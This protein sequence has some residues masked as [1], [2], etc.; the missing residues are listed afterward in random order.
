[1]PHIQS[2]PIKTHITQFHRRSIMV[3][4]IILFFILSPGIILF[5][6]GYRFNFT[7]RTVESTGVLSIDIQPDTANVFVNDILIT[8]SMP[9]RLTNLAPNTYRIRI[10]KPGFHTLIKDFSVHSGETTYL[11]DITLF[12]NNNQQKIAAL[13][14]ITSK[15][16]VSDPNIPIVFGHFYRSSAQFMFTISGATYSE[17]A[18]EKNAHF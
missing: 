2:D 15:I 4:L 11:K 12:K 8:D 9:I 14:S 18:L 6:A 13:D 16:W 3:S 1:M 10:E 17:I 5:T 7:T